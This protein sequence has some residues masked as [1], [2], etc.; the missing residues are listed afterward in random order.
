MQSRTNVY[1]RFLKSNATEYY[2]PVDHCDYNEC[3]FKCCKDNV[4]GDKEYCSDKPYYIFPIIAVIL[5]IVVG[6]AIYVIICIA[7][8]RRAHDNLANKDRQNAYIDTSNVD[9]ATK[10]S[11]VATI[12]PINDHINQEVSGSFTIERPQIRESDI[13]RLKIT[14]EVATDLVSKPPPVPFNAFMEFPRPPS[15]TCAPNSASGYPSISG[16]KEGAIQNL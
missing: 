15:S 11:F 14:P 2:Q 3:E 7:R 10:N 5:A 9:N 13:P 16:S 6:F 12:F 8:R 4:C 1:T